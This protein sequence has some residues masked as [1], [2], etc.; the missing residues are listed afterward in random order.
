M[1]LPKAPAAGSSQRGQEVPDPDASASF[2]DLSEFLPVF[3]G[4]VK[5]QRTQKPHKL[6]SDL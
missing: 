4:F 3:A 5:T 1:F 6:K 2:R